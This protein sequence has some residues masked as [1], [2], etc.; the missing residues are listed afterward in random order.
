MPDNAA[1]NEVFTHGRSTLREGRQQFA[2]FLVLFLL[3]PWACYPDLGSILFFSVFWLLGMW[4]SW[5]CVILAYYRETIRPDDER[6]HFTDVGGPR[7]IVLADVPRAVWQGPPLVKVTL[8]LPT[9]GH[10][11]VEF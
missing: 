4:A 1:M 6:V 10:V 2:F 9:G 3:T 7:T 8:V 11:V 5:Y